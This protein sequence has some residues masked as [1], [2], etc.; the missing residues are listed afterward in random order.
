MS[1]LQSQLLTAVITI[2][3]KTVQGNW[4]NVL[5]Y[6]TNSNILIEK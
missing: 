2:A 1:R 4:R 5:E 6:V 3:L